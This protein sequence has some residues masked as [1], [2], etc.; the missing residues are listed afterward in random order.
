M[1]HDILITGG[2]GTTG[3]YLSAQLAVRGLSY[4]SAT[5]TPNSD[6]DILFD[7]MDDTTWSAAL[8]GVNSI[9]LIAPSGV[10]EPLPVMVPMMQLALRSGARRF[11]LLSASSLDE[12]APMMGRVHA[13]LKEHAR[14]WV[15]LRPTWF[16]QNFSEKQ[17][18]S[19]IKEEAAIYTATGNGRIGFINAEDIAAVAAEAL[20]RS[21]FASGDIILTGPAAIDYDDVA[22]AL[23]NVLNYTVTHH[24]LSVAEL[25]ARHV[26][27]GLPQAYAETLAAMDANIATGTE[28]RVTD[29]VARIVGRPP[30]SIE[31]FVIKHRDVWTTA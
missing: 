17:H 16:M 27:Q 11:V 15:V 6:L 9:Y 23:S 31:D 19:S 22:Q 25:A 29:A 4:R 26:S 30:G 1:P 10:A 5:R 24:Q 7:W 8:E 14:E 21:E 28:D 3:R 13:W 12:G 20:T 2:S 18:L